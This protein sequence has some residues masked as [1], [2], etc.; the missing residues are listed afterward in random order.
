MSTL[1]RLT[2]S[3]ELTTAEQ[4]LQQTVTRV[5][6]TQTKTHSI[7]GLNYV[8]TLEITILC[9]KIMVM[10]SGLEKIFWNSTNPFRVAA[11]Q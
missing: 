9:L 8:L 2:Y 1:S 11:A 4:W 10:E 5:Y 6:L 7:S 3:K